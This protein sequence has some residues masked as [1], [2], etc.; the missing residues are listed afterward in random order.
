MYI[1]GLAQFD[2]DTNPGA[3]FNINTSAIP[4]A[5][6]TPSQIDAALNA[7]AKSSCAG[8]WNPADHSC[9]DTGGPSTCP[10]GYVASGFTC[11][12]APAAGGGGGSSAMPSWVIPVAAALGGLFLLMGMRR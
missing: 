10:S 1:R 4:T 2:Y 11:V 7:I 8:I 9:S 6:A 12:A 3:E 5:T